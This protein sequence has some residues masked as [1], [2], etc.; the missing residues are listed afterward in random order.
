LDLDDYNSD[1]CDGLH[2]TSMG[3]TWMAF[4]QGFGGMR[5]RKGKLHFS[6]FIPEGWSS[7]SFRINFRGAHL[8]FLMDTQH[9]KIVNHSKY[10]LQLVVAGKEM[11]LVAKSQLVIENQGAVV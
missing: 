6:P 10:T 2:I 1:T 5:V 11:E 8:E 7:Y 3:G 9:F 4:V